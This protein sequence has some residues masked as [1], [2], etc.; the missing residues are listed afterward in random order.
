MESLDAYGSPGGQTET[1]PVVSQ[2]GQHIE[3]ATETQKATGEISEDGYNQPYAE[4]AAIVSGDTTHNLVQAG[5]E[6]GIPAS[7]SNLD[8]LLEAIEQLPPGQH[9]HAEPESDPHD[10]FSALEIL[11]AT[12]STHNSHPPSVVSSPPH[13]YSRDVVSAEEPIVESAANTVATDVQACS[14]ADDVGAPQNIDIAQADAE[15]SATAHEDHAAQLG[16]S[17]HEEPP[18]SKAAQEANMTDQPAGADAPVPAEQLDMRQAGGVL[19]RTMC[20]ST[21]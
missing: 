16:M 10:P 14:L 20:C 19:Q 3:N 18:A 9:P 12:A 21:Q 4:S 8:L 2:E 1:P 15:S 11:A 7:G 6:Y 17:L 13:E 5:S